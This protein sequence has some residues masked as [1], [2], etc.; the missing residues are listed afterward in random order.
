V[1][2]YMQVLFLGTREREFTSRYGKKPR[3][4]KVR[5]EGRGRQ[6]IPVTFSDG[7]KGDLI[8]P[9]VIIPGFTSRTGEFSP[10]AHPVTKE[11]TVF[12]VTRD[13]AARLVRPV[14]RVL[15][16]SPG[17]TPALSAMASPKP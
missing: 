13:F 10:M 4:S 9:Q 11:P 5:Y 2:P 8:V 7:E 1:M 15:P 3:V 6:E 16:F 12:P 14:Q 17:G